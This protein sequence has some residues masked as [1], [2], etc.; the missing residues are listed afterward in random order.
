MKLELRGYITNEEVLDF[1][2]VSQRTWY[3]WCNKYSFINKMKIKLNNNVYFPESILNDICNAIGIEIE[4]VKNL[5]SDYYLYRF[6]NG[7]SEVH[8]I[9]ADLKLSKRYLRT[10]LE[11]G[12]FNHFI[13]RKQTYIPK[14]EVEQLHS[15]LI[16]ID[17]EYFSLKEAS[18]I[19]KTERYNIQKYIDKNIFND[20]INFNYNGQRTFISK[21]EVKDF[22]AE[23]VEHLTINQVSEITNLTA[24]TILHHLKKDGFPNAKFMEVHNSYLIPQED[25]NRFLILRDEEKQ[26]KKEA[27]T[28]EAYTSEK[29]LTELIDYIKNSPLSN[30]KTTGMFKG[31]VTFR[32]NSTNGSASFVRDKVLVLKRLYRK[33]DFFKKD[34]KVATETELEEFW[35]SLTTRDAREFNTLLKFLNVKPPIKLVKDDKRYNNEDKEIYSPN[36]FHGYY[37]Y[38]Q[39]V[40]AHIPKAINDPFHANMWAYIILHMTDVWRGNDIILQTPH[41]NI[42]SINIESLEWFETNT[43]TEGQINRIIN[44]LYTTIKNTRTSKSSTLVTFLVEPL[45]RKPL[46]TSLVISELHRRK[47]DQQFLFY[48]FI[49]TRYQQLNTSGVKSHIKFFGCNDELKDF[50]SRKMNSSA[51][52]YLFYHVTEEGGEDAELAI[53]LAQTTRSHKSADSTAIYIK[54]TNKDGSLNRVSLNLFQRGHFGWLYNYLIVFAS[55]NLPLN[56]TLEKRTEAIA[57][58]RSELNPKD[59][60]NISMLINTRLKNDVP[61]VI[62][63]FHKQIQEKNKKLFHN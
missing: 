15:L 35:D 16:K 17:T 10:L 47:N 36:I 43:L 44:Q 12:Y 32:M 40:D 25:V 18:E 42:E 58:M 33:L 3:K 38:V 34:I 49:A 14:S 63:N 55:S 8:D 7:N 46:V 4:K 61:V 45:L 13:Y 59:T 22:I 30:K 27:Y 1:F 60:E 52:T 26:S 53:E 21:K 48:T 62:D 11:N 6:N 9:F 51:L 41:I 20:V 39:K 57:N 19:L 56:H 29:A 50:S 54:A 37:K 23:R 28:S 31:Y 24:S 2:H 5:E